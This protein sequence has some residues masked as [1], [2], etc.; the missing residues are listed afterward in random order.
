MQEVLALPAFDED[1]LYAALDDLCTR[2]EKIEAALLRA[3]VE[4]LYLTWGLVKVEGL[5]VDGATATPESLLNEG[6]ED[7]CREAIR[8]I[9]AECGLTDA[10]R[11]N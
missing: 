5:E 7:L 1:D 4:R 3:E 2:Q 6:P 8:A 9:K 11:K 10:E